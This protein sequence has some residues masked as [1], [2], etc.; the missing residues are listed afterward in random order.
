MKKGGL[1]F[2][3]LLVFA[4][5]CIAQP[6]IENPEK[7][8]SKNAGRVLK[9]QEVW[10]IT[11]EG[12]NFYFKAPG[13]LKV[14]PDGSIFVEDVAEFL[15]FSPD[16]KFIKNLYK[17]GQGPGEIEDFFNYYIYQNKIYIYD[18]M[19]MKLIQT[20]LE[21]NLINQLKIES[22]PYNDFYGVTENWLIFERDIF[23]PQNERKSKLQ[24]VPC[25]V[26]LVSKDG[27]T[28]KESYVFQRIMFLA[29]NAVTSWTRLISILSEDC[30][31]LYVSHTNEYLIE[32]L[33]LEK[34]QIIKRFN[35][36][37]PRVKYTKK[38]WEDEFYK[39][40]NLP[41]RKFEGDVFGLFIDN[42]LLWVK[43]S[44]KDK[45]KGDMFDI[46]DGEGRFVDNFY[47]GLNGSLLTP[48]KGLLYVLEKDSAENWIVVKYKIIQ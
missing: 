41:K 25:A 38:G 27:K 12:G 21:G 9:L 19:P 31:K 14:A 24:D 46:F 17:K 36:K 5:N 35:R 29:P 6:I 20:D 10:R 1:F 33:D 34:G 4:F 8:L 13:D 43:T 23:P 11:D 28:K 45:N 32:L 22:G 16:G 39:K 40:Y 18:G 15:K 48:H 30:K 7:P 42:G 2:Y 26:R 44:T 47:L 37:Y 3:F